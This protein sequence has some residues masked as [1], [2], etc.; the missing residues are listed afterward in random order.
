MEDFDA[1]SVSTADGSG[2]ASTGSAPGKRRE[3]AEE[4][5]KLVERL[6]R[7]IRDDKRHHKPAFDRMR[8]WM[9]IARRGADK[10]WPEAYYTANI[11]GRHI[12]QRVSALYAKNPKIVPRRRDR[13]DFRVW[14]EDPQSLE[15]ALMML[16]SY[17]PAPAGVDPMTGTMLAPMVPPEIQEAQAIIQ[18]ATQGFEL[19]KQAKKFGETLRRLMEYYMA[20]ST[21]LDFKAAAKQLIR[22]TCTC[23]VGYV[24]LDFQRSYDVRP[25]TQNRIADVQ[26]QIRHMERLA[27]D[28]VNGDTGVDRDA[29][30]E[31]LKHQMKALQDQQYVLAREGLV[32]DWPDSTRVIPDK[33]TRNIVGFVGSRHLTIEYLYSAD[34]IREIFGVDLDRK[35][36]LPYRTDGRAWIDE[37]EGSP[38]DDAGM[39]LVWEHY[40]KRTGLVYYLAEGYVGFLKPPEKPSV[41][42]EQTFPVFALTFNSIEHDKEVFP[43]SDVELLYHM[44]KDYNEARQGLREH[45]KAARPRYAFA[46]GALDE[47]DIDRIGNA[48]AHEAVALNLEPGAKIA[49]IIGQIPVSGVD[50]NLYETGQLFTDVQLAVGAQEAQFGAVAK[51]T[52]TEAGIAEGSRVASVGSSVDDLDQFLTSVARAAGNILITEVSAETAAEIVGVGAFWPPQTLDQAAKEYTLEIEAG[53]SGKPNAAQEIANWERLLPFLLQMP[54][55]H[56]TWIARESLRRLDDRADLTEALMEGLPSVVAMN[57]A[58]AS[59]GAPQAGGDPAADPAAQGPEGANNGPQA[60]AGPS[61]SNAPM[62][63][64]QV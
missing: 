56:P 42:V 34:E 62:G 7:R 37:I 54:T 40:D 58:D 64:N 26:Q 60:P 16:Q 3:P 33:L 15:M 29:D 2:Q 50:P 43:P 31:Q 20:E 14:D 39:C 9:E 22:R 13:M 57:R 12:N 4:E 24:K 10:D 36:F 61:G 52:A 49:D 45:R 38:S 1:G 21:P 53:S 55:I 51:A 30:I 41:F 59:A 8:K 25:D 11:T 19:R 32:F 17:V 44:Q 35:D 28:V 27:H 18:D 5:K 6:S 47:E 48:K 46:N 23:G 63:N